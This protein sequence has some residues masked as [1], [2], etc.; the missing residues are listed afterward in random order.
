LSFVLNRE[1]NPQYATYLA[2]IAMKDGMSNDAFVA[3]ID[4]LV[5]LTYL[6]PLPLVPPP[7]TSQPLDAFGAESAQDEGGG[8][9]TKNWTIGACIAMSSGGL[10]ALG[11]WFYKRRFQ[12]K[13][14]VELADDRSDY[15][16]ASLFSAERD[17][18]DDA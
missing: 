14:H 8:S 15:P 11:A 9:G 13:H 18:T 3:N 1:V 4:E 17:F 16:A 12:K 10:L 6:A 7:K 5:K 2:Y